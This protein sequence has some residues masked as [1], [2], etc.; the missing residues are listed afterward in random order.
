MYGSSKVYALGEKDSK[1]NT[2]PYWISETSV[3]NKEML[4]T[5]KVT[6]ARV[7]WFLNAVCF[8]VHLGFAIW[9]LTFNK[10]DG[11]M[12]ITIYRVKGRWVDLTG[13]GY[14]FEVIRNTMPINFCLL[15]ASFFILSAAFHLLACAMGIFES[16]WIFYFRQIDQARCY[17]RWKEYSASASVMAMALAISIG[18]REQNALALIFL[19]HVA[20]MWMGWTCEVYSRPVTRPKTVKYKPTIEESYSFPLVIDQAAWEGDKV[21]T[22]STSD[23]KVDNFWPNYFFRMYPHVLGYFPMTGAWV[24]IVAYYRLVIYDLSVE[25]DDVTIPEWVD[26]ALWGTILIFWSFSF[27]QAIFQ[28]LPP[29]FY[30]RS[31]Y[32]TP[33]HTRARTPSVL[34]R[35]V[36]SPLLHSFALRKSV[37]GPLSPLERNHPRWL[38]RIE[39]GFWRQSWRRGRRRLGLGELACD[40]PCEKRSENTRKALGRGRDKSSNDSSSKEERAE[41]TMSVVEEAF[42]NM[43]SIQFDKENK[44]FVSVHPGHHADPGCETPGWRG[45]T[46]EEGDVNEKDAELVRAWTRNTDAIAAELERARKCQPID[47][48]QIKRLRI[49]MLASQAMRG[50]IIAGRDSHSRMDWKKAGYYDTRTGVDANPSTPPPKQRNPDAEAPGT[51]ERSRRRPPPPDTPPLPPVMKFDLEKADT[52]SSEP[53]KKAPGPKPIVKMRRARLVLANEKIKTAQRMEAVLQLGLQHIDKH[54][55]KA[56][57]FERERDS[58]LWNTQRTSTKDADA[59]ACRN[60]Y[61]IEVSYDNFATSV[62]MR[63]TTILKQI[64]RLPR[65]DPTFEQM[66]Y[67]REMFHEVTD[68][69]SA[70]H[71]ACLTMDED[72]VKLVLESLKSREDK[73]KEACRTD[74]Y[75]QTPLLMM[76]VHMPYFSKWSRNVRSRDSAS[77][78]IFSW[79]AFETQEAYQKSFDAIVLQLVDCGITKHDTINATSNKQ[80]DIAPVSGAPFAP[81]AIHLILLNEMSD[82]VHPVMHHEADEASSLSLQGCVDVVMHLEMRQSGIRMHDPYAPDEITTTTR[83]FLE[84]P[85][86]LD[87]FFEPHPDHKQVDAKSTTFQVCKAEPFITM[88]D[89]RLTTLIEAVEKQRV[90]R[91]DVIEAMQSE[92]TGV[93]RAAMQTELAKLR[94]PYMFPWEKSQITLLGYA[95]YTRNDPVSRRL[96]RRS[97]LYM[98]KEKRETNSLPAQGIPDIMIA[99]Q[100][101]SPQETMLQYACRYSSTSEFAIYAIRNLVGIRTPV[102]K[103]LEALSENAFLDKLGTFLAAF[104]FV[105]MELSFRIPSENEGDAHARMK[106]LIIN[107]ALESGPDLYPREYNTQ[108]T[109]PTP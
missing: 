5:T 50:M 63:N 30:C 17:W 23:T 28:Y 87:A 44:V 91:A 77:P 32:Q 54:L 39:S 51:D 74:A 57:A 80:D 56:H 89:Y 18:I 22:S 8:L 36:R 19:C 2:K 26:G 1:S 27:V 21:A 45:D 100:V 58:Y 25:R 67:A 47:Q 83:E 86:G 41:C 3:V 43:L 52:P 85:L 64:A 84:C 46:E 24:V 68:G 88:V 69:A 78:P 66:R 71:L 6:A 61:R 33:V 97:P 81:A 37:P 99:F 109:D 95:L 31:P 34:R 29:G 60:L 65:Q 105:D 107:R 12:D 10:T 49:S 103:G 72:V 16:T 42:K 82:L 90:S 73:Q 13:D 14:E 94:M 98:Q 102:E 40:A 48:V 92:L 96:I 75:N 55:N 101:A 38:G 108:S 104:E 79:K 9:T 15:T 11:T 4:W 106:S 35:G 70:L 20:C 59:S 7:I 93:G 53:Q 62:L 76:L